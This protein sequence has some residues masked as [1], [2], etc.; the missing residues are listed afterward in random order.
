MAWVYQLTRPLAGLI[1][2]LGLVIGG[3]SGLSA[4]SM[5]FASLP[6]QS[7]ASANEVQGSLTEPPTPSSGS[8]PESGV[9]LYGQ[10]PEP[11]QIGSAYA[12]LEVVG[13]RTVGAFYMPH[14]SF[15]CFYGEVRPNQLALTVVNSYE[16]VAYGYSVALQRDGAIASG[17]NAINP[18]TKL[19]GYHRIANLSDRDRAI[20][21][22]CRTT[23]QEQL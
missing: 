7:S 17:Q 11:N 19:A 23:H 16:Q 18:P 10:S 20:L 21:N 1:L 3:L 4:R 2:A 8:F 22:T 6:E 13:D 12:V 9:Y 14:S 5:E 15:D